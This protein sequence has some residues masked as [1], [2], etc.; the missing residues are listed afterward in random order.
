MA[1][2]RNDTSAGAVLFGILVAIAGIYWLVTKALHYWPITVI[3]VLAL[4]L[5]I[6]YWQVKK[7]EAAERARQEAQEAYEAERRRWREATFEPGSFSV[8]LSGFGGYGVEQ[9]LAT[10]LGDLPELRDQQGDEVWA[11]LERVVHVA[12]QAIAER[13]AQREA[14]RLKVALEERGARAK[15]VE[16]AARRRNGSGREPIS[17]A[18]RR[19]V[20]RRDG[21][22]CV[23][24]GSRERLEYDHIVPVSRGGAHTARNIELR[25]ETCNRRKGARL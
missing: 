25:C 7:S 24:C 12:P 21:G 3:V 8:V 18:V 9:E 22:Q 1:R 17:A 19:E 13:V 5:L 14:V 10:F 2:R 15:I 11:L 16:G 4:G 6:A 23:D 20:W